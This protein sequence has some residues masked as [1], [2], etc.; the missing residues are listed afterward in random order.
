MLDNVPQPVLLAFAGLGALYFI[1][2][3]TR[4]VSIFFNVFLIPGTNL[5]KY[6]KKG[7]W[8]IITGASEG[9][10]REFAIQL[11]AKGFNVV[12]IARTKT[13]LDALAAELKDKYA[14]SGLETKVMTMDYAADNDEDYERLR[15]V[16]SNL[17]VGVLVNNVGL[18]HGI[19][20]PFLE[21][22]PKELQNIITINCLGTLKTTA[23]VAPIMKKRK[24][25]L[26]L[27]MG[28]FGGW[29]PTPLLATYSGSK[30][31]LQHWSSALAQELKADGVDV[32][33]VLSYLVTTAMSKIRRTSI[34]IPSPQKF[35]KSALSKVGT[36][37]WM[38]TAYTYVPWWSHALMAGAI[39]NTVGSGSAIGIWFNHIMHM[40][41]RTRALRKAAREAKKA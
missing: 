7:T 10:G 36:G 11:A 25:G 5:R 28:S 22:D 16:I 37:G 13:K 26:I 6:G 18:S 17:D 29:M 20:V 24:N 15:D 23:V 31:F 4:F 32:Q 34:M 19:P 12:L 33:L 9:I 3:A 2:Q 14:S 30:A 41:I 1:F 38:N 27:T 21:T 8:A 40:D 35:V 39:E